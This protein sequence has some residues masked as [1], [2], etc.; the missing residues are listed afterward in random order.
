[1][2]VEPWPFGKSE[3]DVEIPARRV[4]RHR[5]DDVMAFRRAY[6]AAPV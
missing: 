4:P 2:I 3:I 6:A 5:F 1:V